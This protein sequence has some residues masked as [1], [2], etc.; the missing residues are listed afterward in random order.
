MTEAEATGK[1]GTAA[2]RV[3]LLRRLL[4]VFLRALFQVIFHI[5]CRIEIIGRENIPESGGYMIAHN[6]ISLY[7]PPLVLA[8]WPQMPEAIAGSDVFERPGIGLLVR[9][10]G[11]IPVRRGEYDRK[12]ID[13]MMAALKAGKPLSIAPEGG[14]SHE[15]SLRQAQAGVA[16]MIDRAGVP[17]LPVGITGTT[18]NMLRRALKGQRPQLLMQIG[19]PFLPPPIAGKGEERR[20]ARQ[21]NADLVMRKIA[22]LVPEDYRGIYAN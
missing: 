11:A 1:I 14:R 21:D 16:Y 17:V 20:Q 12:V 8:F 3:P 22:E 13:T 7:E 5:I 9:A 2:Y 10:Y 19:Q 6:H 18:K 15:T 4:R